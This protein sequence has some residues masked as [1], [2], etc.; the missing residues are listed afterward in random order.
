MEEFWDAAKDFNAY[1]R[2]GTASHQVS[3]FERIKQIPLL[4][5]ALNELAMKEGA[6][7]S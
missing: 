6:A 1:L 3:S 7:N 2:Q 4:K 5:A